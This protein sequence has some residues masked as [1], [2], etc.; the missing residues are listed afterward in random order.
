MMVSNFLDI[1]QFFQDGFQF[2]QD[3]FQFFQDFFK[4][5]NTILVLRRLTAYLSG[6]LQRLTAYFSGLLRR[7]TACFSG[8]LRRLTAC[9]SAPLGLIFLA[10]SA[11]LEWKGGKI[12]FLKLCMVF[13]K[14]ISF[15]YDKSYQS[16]RVPLSPSLCLNGNRLS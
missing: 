12:E 2:F 8:P 1:F 14:V 9:F 15:I 13:R 7:L 3:I 4:C 16:D 11:N 6:P 5:A 10:K